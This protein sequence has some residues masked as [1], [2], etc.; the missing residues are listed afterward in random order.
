MFNPS[1]NSNAHNC[2]SG[3][4]TVSG[5]CATYA[6][7]CYYRYTD[8]SVNYNYKYPIVYNLNCNADAHHC[9]SGCCASDGS[10]AITYSMCSYRYYDQ[11]YNYAYHYPDNG[12]VTPNY[13][14]NAIINYNHN[15][16]LGVSLGVSAGY[17]LLVIIVL[18]ICYCQR[19]P[20]V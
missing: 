13:T 14:N 18:I 1:C 3:C 17:L 15:K 2:Q 20:F 12:I 10:C 5:A 16:A 19:K 4:C 7:E 11:S 9:V 6:L 8:Y